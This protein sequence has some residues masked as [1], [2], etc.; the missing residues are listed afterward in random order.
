MNELHASSWLTDWRPG[1]WGTLFVAVVTIGYVAAWIRARRRGRA[2]VSW[3]AW[4]LTFGAG[5]L[6]YTLCGPR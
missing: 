3:L 6:A 4:F 5:G 1:S 2:N